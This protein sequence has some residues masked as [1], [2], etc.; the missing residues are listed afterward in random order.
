MDGSAILLSLATTSSQTPVKKW[1]FVPTG[2]FVVDEYPQGRAHIGALSFDDAQ[3]VVRPLAIHVK[4]WIFFVMRRTDDPSSMGWRVAA[5]FSDALHVF[6]TLHGTGDDT[7]SGPM[8]G[9]SYLSSVV[10]L[11]WPILHAADDDE[12]SEGLL[13]VRV[14]QHLGAPENFRAMVETYTVEGGTSA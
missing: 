11:A 7:N 10:I 9:A 13:H 12:L 8:A 4:G 1:R 14:N 6:W 3:F 5:F 2:E